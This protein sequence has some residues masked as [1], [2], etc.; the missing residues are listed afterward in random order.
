MSIPQSSSGCIASSNTVSE[1]QASKGLTPQITFDDLGLMHFYTVATSMTIEPTLDLRETWQVSAPEEAASHPFLMH[2]LLAMA[3]LHRISIG[4]NE[5]ERYMTLAVKHHTLALVGSKPELELVSESNCHALF[6]FSA[7]I[8]ISALAIPVCRNLASLPD[9]IG[10]MVQVALLMR[11][12][13]AIVHTGFQWLETGKFRTLLHSVFIS[14]TDPVL[15]DVEGVLM[16]V[17][18]QIE[19]ASVPRKNLAAYQNAL[20]YLRVCF[21]GIFSSQE[22]NTISVPPRNRG[23][24]W[25]WLA[26]VEVDFITLLSQKDPRALIILAHYAVLLHALD[27]FWWCCGWG[28][29]LITSVSQ[30]VGNDWQLSLSWPNQQ[31]RFRANED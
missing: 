29:A 15:E 7:M 30:S 23:V 31:I 8:A 21:R 22:N 25:S 12:S 4:T 13:S 9:P 17:Q 3:A 16:N 1:Q 27:E 14:Q 20:E 10:E 2:S 26:T 28:S 11:G 19:S 6:A 24:V 18:I 5:H